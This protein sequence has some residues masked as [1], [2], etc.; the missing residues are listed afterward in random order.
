MIVNVLYDKVDIKENNEK[1]LFIIDYLAK[2]RKKIK[3][4]N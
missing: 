4:D 3:Y 2:I 1:A